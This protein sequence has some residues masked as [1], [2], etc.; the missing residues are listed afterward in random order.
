MKLINIIISIIL[1]ILLT[2]QSEPTT[3]SLFVGNKVTNFG[4]VSLNQDL[5]HTFIITCK[6]KTPVYI[7]QILANN[8]DKSFDQL[9]FSFEIKYKDSLNF[10]K[11]INLNPNSQFPILSY[12]DSIKF[13][14]SLK[15]IKA[16]Y[17]YQ[18]IILK[19]DVKDIYFNIEWTV[20]LSEKEKNNITYYKCEELNLRRE[21]DDFTG[22]ISISSPIGVPLSIHKDIVN[23]IPS[24][25]VYLRTYGYTLNVAGK[26]VYLLFTDGSK[27]SKPSELINVDNTS[28]GK[29][30]YSARCNSIFER[31]RL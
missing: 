14:V 24:Y 31:F 29:W 20:K 12:G 10:V 2:S 15:V 5:T 25:F 26:G 23:K 11:P 8:K 7:S 19:N 6:S 18:F 22:N 9:G 28:S 16:G 13:K 30:E 27:I 4:D 1:F 17:F 21:V 3:A